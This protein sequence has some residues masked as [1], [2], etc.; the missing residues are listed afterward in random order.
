MMDRGDFD[1]VAVGRA[2]TAAERAEAGIGDAEEWWVLP[3]DGTARKVEVKGHTIQFVKDCGEEAPVFA[4][5]LDS[6]SDQAL[7]LLGTPP[8]AWSQPSPR[9]SIPR[10]EAQVLIREQLPRYFQNRTKDV[11]IAEDQTGWYGW[12]EW[13]APHPSDPLYRQGDEMTTFGYRLPVTLSE[14]RKARF[15]RPA[16]QALDLVES[17]PVM[18]RDLDGDGTTEVMWT[19]CAKRWTHQEVDVASDGDVCCGC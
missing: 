17:K 14:D 4:T 9:S 19:G 1:L 10:A 6:A 13:A 5:E 18:R 7:A 8:A 11:V 2:L 15:G 3:P 16:V 12:V